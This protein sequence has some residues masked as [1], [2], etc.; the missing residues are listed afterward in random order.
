MSKGGGR[1]G[2]GRQI[3]QSEERGRGSTPNQ[4]IRSG[5]LN[6]CPMPVPYRHLLLLIQQK[7]VIIDPEKTGGFGIMC[8]RIAMCMMMNNP[9][10]VQP[11]DIG[12]DSDEGGGGGGGRRCGGGRG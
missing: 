1:D 10:C 9:S 7:F 11:N 12:L 5:I 4:L 2:D 6:C 8:E 3:G